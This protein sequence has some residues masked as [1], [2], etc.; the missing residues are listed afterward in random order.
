MLIQWRA[1]SQCSVSM[2]SPSRGAVAGLVAS[3]ADMV[4]TIRSLLLIFLRRSVYQ[5]RMKPMSARRGRPDI[6]AATRGGDNSV[7]MDDEADPTTASLE[8]ALFWRNIY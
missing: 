6:V 1:S 7:G 5:V 8:A 2:S 4:L 3:P